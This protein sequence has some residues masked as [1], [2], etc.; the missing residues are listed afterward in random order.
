MEQM[1]GARRS[2][3]L[4]ARFEEVAGDNG[5]EDALTQSKREHTGAVEVT[6]RVADTVVVEEAKEAEG[7]EV[8]KE[9]VDSR[10]TP[11]EV[12]SRSVSLSRNPSPWEESAKSKDRRRHRC[13]PHQTWPT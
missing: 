2:G 3:R 7:G 13:H 10:T 5:R 11:R 12:W 1:S 6:R 4:L 8:A 9:D